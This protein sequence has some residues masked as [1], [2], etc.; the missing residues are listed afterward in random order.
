ME[1]MCWLAMTKPDMSCVPV[2]VCRCLVLPWPMPS[3]ASAGGL[4]AGQVLLSFWLPAWPASWAAPLTMTERALPKRT[5][6]RHKLQLM[7]ASVQR[8][9]LGRSA[10]W[11]TCR[12]GLLL[13]YNPVK[14][15]GQGGGTGELHVHQT[16]GCVAAGLKG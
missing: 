5:P 6:N 11:R 3:L 10:A 1:V 15:A 9:L 12:A 4:W 16:H 8:V 7:Q 13:R 14:L 2:Y